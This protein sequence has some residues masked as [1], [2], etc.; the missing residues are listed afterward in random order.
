LDAF[1][2]D[3]DRNATNDSVRLAIFELLLDQSVFVK[4]RRF[5]PDEGP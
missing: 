3:C 5:A 4:Q 1:L 2:S